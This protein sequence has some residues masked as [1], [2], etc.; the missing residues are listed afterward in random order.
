MLRFELRP[1]SIRPGVEVIELWEDDRLIGEITPTS[2]SGE[3]RVISKYPI[4][5]VQ[6][7]NRPGDPVSFAIRILGLH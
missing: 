7:V 4:R 5:S 6:E 2:T 1:H 3:F